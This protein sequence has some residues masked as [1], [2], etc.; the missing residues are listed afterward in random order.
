MRLVFLLALAL[1]VA[2]ALD[3]DAQSIADLPCERRVDCL[4]EK[5]AATDAGFYAMVETLRRAL[6][7]ERANHAMTKRELAE[8]TKERDALLPKKDDKK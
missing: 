6:A 3:V 8:M 5:M 4:N 1:A 7:L 2:V